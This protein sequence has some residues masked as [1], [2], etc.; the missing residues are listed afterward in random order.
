[1]NI[2]IAFR[3]A[4]K[5]RSNAARIGGQFRGDAVFINSK[6]KKGMYEKFIV[7]TE[8]VTRSEQIVG[9]IT[10]DD[11]LRVY[12]QDAVQAQEWLT[13]LAVPYEMARDVPQADGAI[14][15]KRTPVV[16]GSVVHFGG[17]GQVREARNLLPGLI[18]LN[19]W[20]INV[21]S[22]NLPAMAEYPTVPSETD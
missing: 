5:P 14:L 16:P 10:F 3:F 20:E 17:L 8:T 1:M 18:I 11:V 19:D 4:L 12:A 22:A 15:W 9:R 7:T 13:A 6:R 2:E 21:P